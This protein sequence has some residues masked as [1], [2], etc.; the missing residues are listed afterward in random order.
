MMSA[1]FGFLFAV[2]GLWGLWRYSDELLAVLKGL[3]PLSF[4]L[5]GLIAVVIG[6]TSLKSSGG[7]K[8]DGSGDKKQ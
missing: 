2:A 1:F 5:G 3:L 4:F 7:K 8:S 6:L